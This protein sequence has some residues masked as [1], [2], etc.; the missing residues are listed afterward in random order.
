MKVKPI[1]KQPVMGL[2][3]LVLLGTAACKKSFYTDVNNNPNAPTAASIVPSVILPPIETSIGYLQGGDLSRFAAL[4]LQQVFGFNRQSDANY[5]YIYTAQTFDNVWGNIFTSVLQ[6]DDVLLQLANAKG[7]HA[8]AGIAKV[9][10]AYMLQVTVDTWGPVPYTN[11]LKGAGDLRPTYDNDKVLYDTIGNMLDAGIA[12]LMNPDPG[13][14]VP[15]DEDFLYGGKADK[16]IRFAHAIKSRLFMHQSKGDA[17]MANKALQEMAL[18]FTSN[19]D[20]AQY[21]F[22]STET[23]ANP[24]Y[25]F[26]QQRTDISFTQGKVADIMMT[27]HDPRFTILIDTTDGGDNLK[28]YGVTDAPVEFITYDELQ[29][30]TAEAV[31]R[32]GGSIVASQA[33]YQQG[34]QANMSKLGV[35]QADITAY[36]AAHGTLP[37]DPDQAIAQIAA[38]AYLAL[39][40]NP[41]AWT[42]WRRTNSPAL[43]P[44]TGSNIPRR[45]LY[46]QTEYSYNKANV[47]G[48]VTLFSPKIFW[49]K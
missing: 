10:R 2:A 20:N 34:I 19:A 9:L 15:G 18:S 33:F 48:S 36:I 14:L 35:Q 49:D 25:Q 39:Y 37:A 8:Y 45:L 22:G 3:V 47:P 21:K 44:V 31:L 16:W 29:F 7:F 27:Q 38:E 26:N 11:A 28:Y 43:T 41:E 4:N 30:A 24:W 40:L 46:P 17:V 32:N 6:N 42:V 13:A 23:T 1:Y 12:D 5:R